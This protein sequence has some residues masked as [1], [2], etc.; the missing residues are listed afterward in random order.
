MNEE[1]CDEPAPATAN[2]HS[3]NLTVG[4]IGAGKMAI[5]LAKGI[6]KRGIVKA[7]RILASAPTD[8][9][10]GLFTEAGMRT[11]RDNGEVVRACKVVFIA[12]KPPVV[13]AAL[14]DIRAEVTGDHLIVSIAAGITIAT[15]EKELPMGARVVRLMPNTACQ[16]GEGAMVFARGR[17]TTPEE[18]LL[19]QE[20]LS[21]CGMCLAVPEPYIDI[22]TGMSGS[23]IAYAY[24]FAEAL[25]DGA[26]K[27]G[28]T[29]AVAGDIAAQTLLGAGRMLLQTKAHPSQLKDDVSSPGGTTI[30]GIHEL[31]KGNF[32]STVINAVETATARANHLGKQ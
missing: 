1:C 4:F 21:H 19:L 29:R 6:L 25:A 20:L 9:S 30:Y 5:S 17:S 13:K 22:H 7:D 26:V 28:M 8:R 24:M 31:E 11:T 3:A 23:G 14:A 12:T 27:M 18:A 32:R 16:V 15:L 10:T 2:F